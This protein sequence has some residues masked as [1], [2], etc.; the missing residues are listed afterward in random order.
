M[1]ALLNQILARLVRIETRLARLMLNSGLTV[2]GDKT[3]QHHQ[4]KRNG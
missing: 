3:P 1:T 2:D 4:E